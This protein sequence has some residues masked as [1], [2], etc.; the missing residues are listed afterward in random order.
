MAKSVLN[1]LRQATGLLLLLLT[2]TSALWPAPRA[3]GERLAL[4]LRQIGHDY[5][6]AAGDT[7]STIPA[8]T[9]DD[10]GKLLLRLERH[11]AYD[12]LNRIARIVLADYGIT[13]D[14][15]L[16]LEDCRSGQ[17]FLGSLWPGVEVNEVFGDNDAACLGR[18]QDERCAN[19]GLAVARTGRAGVPVYIY[20]LGGLGLLLL[21][22]GRVLPQRHPASAPPANVGL[23]STAPTTPLRLRTDCTFDASGQLLTVGARRHELT[24]RE[25]KLFGF[26]ASHPN[27]VLARADINQAVWGEEGIIT[28]RS[29]DVFVSRLRK[30]IAAADGVEIQTVH[31]VGYRL[32]VGG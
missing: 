29:L 6:T 21:L 14:Y 22:A 18:D 15:T 32:M 13:A 30:K 1:R 17:V 4:A 3:E 2:L 28:G 23:I 10:E 16:T 8:V 25:A 20:V 31:G 11:L 9:Q 24:Y 12:S 19:V 27:E 26:F 5:L 7:S